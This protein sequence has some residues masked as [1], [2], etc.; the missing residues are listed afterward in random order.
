MG[1]KEKKN[2][3]QK[4]SFLWPNVTDDSESVCLALRHRRENSSG[5]AL[6]LLR[7]RAVL[8]IRS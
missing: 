3:E 7:C 4:L 2:V 8:L 5:R 6:M 1:R